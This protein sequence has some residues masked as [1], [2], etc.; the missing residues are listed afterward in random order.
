MSDVQTLRS[1]NTATSEDQSFHSSHAR[2]S[3]ESDERN[4]LIPN[5][6][7]IPTVKWF[8]AEAVF[9]KTANDV[10]GPVLPGGRNMNLWTDLWGPDKSDSSE[11][12]RQLKKAF[13][14]EYTRSMQRLSHTRAGC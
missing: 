6:R 13:L 7:V 5:F 2:L 3:D 14:L 11:Q 10:W 1:I 9:N 12:M 8:V 4:L